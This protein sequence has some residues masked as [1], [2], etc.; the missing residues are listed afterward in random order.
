MTATPYL[1]TPLSIRPVTLEDTLEKMNRLLDQVPAGVA[2]L[3]AER[4]E[5][6]Q[7][8]EAVETKVEHLAAGISELLSATQRTAARLD[9][10]RDEAAEG[11]R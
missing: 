1:V 11:Q 5:T 7:R 6:F 4:P 2:A 3:A 8:L 10:D 9:A